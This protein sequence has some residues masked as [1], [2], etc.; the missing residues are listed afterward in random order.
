MRFRL[1]MIAVLAGLASCVAGAQDFSLHNG[2]RVLFYGDSITD[3]RL[4][5]RDVEI[6]TRTRFPDL[7]VSFTNSGVG[8]DSVVGGARGT[9]TPRLNRDVFP[10]KPTV[11]TM[12]LGMNDGHYHEFDPSVQLAY[13]TGYRFILDAFQKQL[14]TAK[15]ILIQPS[16]YDDITRAPM[17]AG[18]YN[19]V[20]LKMSEADAKFADERKLGLAD[21]NTAVN[22]TLTK[23]NQSNPGMAQAL[24]V[25]RV[26]PGPQVHWIMA[27][28][29]LKAMQAT[30][31]VSKVALQ[32]GQKTATTQANASVTALTHAAGS[33]TWTETE[34]S[35]PLPL[36][37]ADDP[38]MA[39]VVQSS[40]LLGDLDE[41]TLSVAG[42]P[43]AQY[44]LEIDGRHIADYSAT[45]LATGIN[46]ATERTPMMEQAK[47]VERDVDLHQQLEVLRYSQIVRDPADTSTPATIQTLTEAIARVQEQ[48]RKD[49]HPREHHYR[50]TKI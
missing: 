46:L 11:I 32:F 10:F 12:M 41:E 43:A 17:F 21:F 25:D 38:A 49:A 6:Y 40:T 24:I 1:S 28:A 31:V 50:I 14:P 3:Q 29:L 48:A 13:E 7:D 23:A 15:E 26:H 45:D 18:G 5:T 47:V 20:L 19:G 30:P 35:L 37:M 4:Y 42:L 8:G 9:I 39:L 33:M 34:N 27:D 44:A 16:P 36:P 2:D 22:A